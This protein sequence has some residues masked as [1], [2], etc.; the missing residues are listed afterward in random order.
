MFGKIILNAS[1][2][3]VT[4]TATAVLRE[5]ISLMVPWLMVMTAVIIADLASGVR[6]CLKL[7][8]KVSPSTAFRETIS[9]WLVYIAF[10]LAVCMIDVVANDD[11][12][13]AKW[14]C[15]FVV[16]FEMGSIVSNILRPYGIIITPK[17]LVKWFLRK[18]PL[19]DDADDLI[20][21]ENIKEAKEYEN[22]KWNMRGKSKKHDE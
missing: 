6:K 8:V 9:K 16:V 22:E 15:L 7:G 21:E 20:K 1:S 5:S 18:T 17:G 3:L 13:F 11:I 19:G 10:V 14:A 4:A 2:I 12:D